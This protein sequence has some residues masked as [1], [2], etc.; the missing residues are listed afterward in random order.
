MRFQIFS[1]LARIREF[2]SICQ[3]TIELVSLAR[4]ECA[5]IAARIFLFVKTRA[6]R[7]IFEKRRKNEALH[8]YEI[9]V[10][11]SF[12]KLNRAYFMAERA[13]IYI[14]RGISKIKRSYC[15]L[16]LYLIMNRI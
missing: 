8:I 9:E 1:D 4:N 12:W 6:A 7:N 16:L 5:L 10:R 14:A 11:L 13:G 2:V 15:G 3:Q